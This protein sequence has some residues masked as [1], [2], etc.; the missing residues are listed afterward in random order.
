MDA[1]CDLLAEEKLAVTMISFY[2]SEDVLRKVLSHPCATVGSD[3]IYGG[4]PH[5]RLYGSYPR[6]LRQYVRESRTFTLEEAVR[7]ITSFPAKILG[8]GDRGTVEEGKWATWCSSTPI[9]WATDRPTRNRNCTGGNLLGPC[10]RR[11]GGG[12]DG[13]TGK[14]PGKVLRKGR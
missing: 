7:K 13:T 6:F 2:G 12:A 3:G 1:V 4:R 8:L 10:Q 5:P 11:G 14:M 9:P